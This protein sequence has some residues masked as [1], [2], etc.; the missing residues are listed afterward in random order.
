MPSRW[1]PRLL[2][3]GLLPALVQG[4][5]YAEQRWLEVR[6]D[7]F[8]LVSNTD[9]EATKRIARSFEEFRALAPILTGAQRAAPDLDTTIF[10]FGDEKSW[11]YFRPTKDVAGFFTTDAEANYIGLYAAV[12]DERAGLRTALH[13][14]VHLLARNQASS[15]Q[16]PTWYDEGFAEAISTARVEGDEIV[17]GAPPGGY[18]AL[19]DDRKWL[20]LE[21]VV[22]ARGYEGLGRREKQ[23][24]YAQ[25]WLFVHRLTWG[26]VMGLAERHDQILPYIER[27]SRGEPEEKAFRKAF[28]GSYEKLEGELR[29]Y[30]KEGPPEIVV[31]AP[32]PAF[33]SE[34][35]TRALTPREHLILLGGFQL[36]LGEEGAVEAEKLAHRALESAPDDAYAILLLDNAR[37]VRGE[38]PGDAGTSRALTLAPEDPRVQRGVGRLALQRSRS[39]ELS[40]DARRRL[41][42]QARDAYSRANALTPDVPGVLAGLGYARLALGESA[43]AHRAFREAFRLARWDLN[44]ALILGELQAQSGDPALARRLLREV[45]GSAH[46]AELRKRAREALATLDAGASTTD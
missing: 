15:G 12:D 3:L 33:E 44:L 2:L 18:L 11:S 25:S 1:L 41:A 39:P 23:M 32:I 5:P 26:H 22:T 19:L 6:T 8:R 21:R 40:V 16:Y 43:A 4:E 42:E 10:V 45:V 7:A 34:P 27:V 17:V 31:S 35:R 14:Y 24:L 28:G 13:E 38:D 37:A 9:E 20:P 30:L 46:H 29:K 36:A